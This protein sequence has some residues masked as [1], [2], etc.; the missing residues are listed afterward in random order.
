MNQQQQV[1]LLV[2]YIMKNC[3][4]QF[5]SRSWD[6]E[7]QNAGILEKTRQLLCDEPVVLETPADRCYWVDAV[8]LADAYRSRFAWLREMTKTAI[9]EL[10][11]ALHK[12][13]DY[14]TI[15]GSLNAELTDQRY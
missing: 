5:H 2:D 10:M 8:V 12:R 15:T 3:L 13:M 11:T 9:A 6:R 1:E 14:L 4:W 7:K